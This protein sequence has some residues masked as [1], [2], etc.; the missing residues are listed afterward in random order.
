MRNAVLFS[1]ALAWSTAATAAVAAYAPADHLDYDVPKDAVKL[2]RRPTR[3]GGESARYL[4][5]ASRKLI[6]R[7]TYDPAGVMT[8]RDLFKGGK[9]HGVQREWHAS[10]QKK[11]EAPYRD[12]VMDGV[13]R[14]WDAKGDLVGCYRMKNGTGTKR[15]YH[16][17]G[18]LKEEQPYLE[19]KR[20]GRLVNMFDKGTVEYTCMWKSGE[21][22]GLAF[23][24]HYNNPAIRFI[25]NADKNGDP[26]GPAVDYRQEGQ[27][28]RLLLCVHGKD[29]SADAYRKA[30]ETD[31]TLP[32]YRKDP[33]EYRKLLTPRVRQL[34]DRYRRLPPVKIPLDGPVDAAAFLPQESAPAPKEV[35][36]GAPESPAPAPA[37]ERDNRVLVLGAVLVGTG[38]VLLLLL[39]VLRR[40]RTVS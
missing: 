36:P 14:H 17:N 3:H 23:G 33:Q 5:P 30:C 35:R 40:R 27:V 26:H 9:K 6:C 37:R 31:A 15:V 19:N 13:F 2:P 10:G 21:P 1:I 16:P 34:M 29:V 39:F 8:Q 7:E 12:G 28:E 4:D 18:R 22:I 25:G 38:V 20:H 24:F 32:R 11:L